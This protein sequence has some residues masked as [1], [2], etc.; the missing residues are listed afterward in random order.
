MKLNLKGTNVDERGMKAILDLY[1]QQL[2][3]F[4]IDRVAIEV[5]PNAQNGGG[6]S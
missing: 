5:R 4:K 2:E 1:G 6:W 3:V